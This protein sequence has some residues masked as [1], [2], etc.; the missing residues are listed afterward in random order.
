MRERMKMPDQKWIAL[1]RQE[2]KSLRVQYLVPLDGIILVEIYESPNEEG[3][4]GAIIYEDQTDYP[5]SNDPQEIMAQIGVDAPLI[6][7]T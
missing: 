6:R 4:T 5:F 2:E 7:S 1:R 3:Q